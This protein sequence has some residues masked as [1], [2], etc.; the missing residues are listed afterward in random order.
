MNDKDLPDLKLVEHHEHMPPWCREPDVWAVGQVLLKWLGIFDDD[1]ARRIIR[2]LLA[3]GFDVTKRPPSARA[4]LG[5][6]LLTSINPV[7]LPKAP[8]VPKRRKRKPPP[9]AK[10]PKP[11]AGKRR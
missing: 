3:A 8:L 7:D 2:D 1:L 4:P 9:R 5:H 11:K 6:A 10:K